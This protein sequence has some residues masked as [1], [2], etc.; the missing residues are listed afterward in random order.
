MVLLQDTFVLHMTTCKTARL[1][2]WQST[3]V[4]YLEWQKM[5]ATIV[6]NGRDIHCKLTAAAG[7][8][9]NGNFS[10]KE[11]I[12]RSHFVQG[13][14]VEGQ[15]K[16]LEQTIGGILQKNLLSSLARAKTALQFLSPLLLSF[17][18]PSFLRKNYQVWRMINKF[19]KQL[20]KVIKTKVFS[21]IWWG[22]EAF[23]GEAAEKKPSS[24]N[25]KLGGNCNDL[26]KKAEKK[27]K[28]IFSHHPAGHSDQA[29][30]LEGRPHHRPPLLLR[31]RAR[32][33]K[34]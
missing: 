10:L 22:E 19:H 13:H 18:P 6:R 21:S 28:T 31:R 7:Q 17:L 2:V 26:R 20:W 33:L 30:G 5:A 34:W 29:L 15:T 23:E 12:F 4:T 1:Q 11:K 25:G 16:S 8:N 24:S 9:I 3:W 14:R 27:R 32:L